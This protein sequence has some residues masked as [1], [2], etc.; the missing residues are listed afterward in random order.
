MTKYDYLYNQNLDKPS[1]KIIDEPYTVNVGKRSDAQ[2]S[3][4]TVINIPRYANN[5]TCNCSFTL[6]DIERGLNGKIVYIGDKYLIGHHLIKI[7]G[8]TPTNQ[9]GGI[10]GGDTK[11]SINYK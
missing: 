6:K 4:V 11:I 5:I 8:Y 7:E 3:H 10:I 1:I 2:L 9:I